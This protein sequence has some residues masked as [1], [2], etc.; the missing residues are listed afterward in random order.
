MKPVQ[1]ARWLVA[2][3][4]LWL[5]AGAGAALL[6]APTPDAV[7]TCFPSTKPVWTVGDRGYGGPAD[8]RWTYALAGQA[9]WTDYRVDCR[10]HLAKP[11]TDRGGMETSC[12]AYFHALAN[13]GGYEAAVVV[14]H[15]SPTKHY[16]VAVSSLWKELIVWRPTG[17]VVQVVPY[18]FEAGKAYDL[19]VTCRGACLTVSV[20]GKELVTWWD[21]ADP[22]PAGRVGLARKEGEAYFASVKVDAA[23]AQKQSPPPHRARFREVKWHGYRFFFDSNEPVFLV[24]NTNLLDHMKFVPGYRPILYTF[25]FISDWKRFY[26][27]KITDSKLEYCI[28]FESRMMSRTCIGFSAGWHVRATSPAGYSAEYLP[29]A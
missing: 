23:P 17:G 10:I 14:R 8:G 4:L 21:T 24:T 6:D 20:N 1:C 2:F 7:A 22:V 3:G 18:P 27:T 9:G 19:S 28:T 26:T 12:F 11:A 16:R 13:L 29:W 25:N 5:P 15:A